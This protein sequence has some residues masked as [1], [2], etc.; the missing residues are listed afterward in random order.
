[1]DVKNRLDGQ[2]GTDNSTSFIQSLEIYTDPTGKTTA[3]WFVDLLASPV[4]LESFNSFEITGD[5][6]EVSTYGFASE[7][8][9]WTVGQLST[10]LQIPV[11]IKQLAYLSESPFPST[12]I[13]S[14]SRDMAFKEVP[15]SARP[16]P[17]FCL[18]KNGLVQGYSKLL[19]RGLAGGALKYDGSL[20]PDAIQF[21]WRFDEESIPYLAEIMPVI[22]DGCS[23]AMTTVEDGF[24]NYRD[25]EYPAPWDDV[26]G[27]PCT[28]MAGYE[29]RG[30]RLGAPQWIPN[31]HIG[32]ITSQSLDVYSEALSRISSGERNEALERLNTLANDGAGPY[33]IHGINTL[34]YSF[35]LPKLKEHP[36]VISEVEYLARQNIEQCMVDQSTNAIANL[37]ISYFLVGDL[38]RSEQTLLEALE[39]KDKFAEDEASFFLNLVYS[40][41]GEEAL[42]TEYK[43][44]SDAAG[45]YEPPEWFEPRQSAGQKAESNISSSVLGQNPFC[46]G[47]GNK[48]TSDDQKFCPNC[49]SRR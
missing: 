48:F 18:R 46:S 6:G 11:L 1:L 13:M 25:L 47:C 37:G 15:E 17:F 44:R 12:Q 49:G 16:T 10:K 26:V 28:F 32:E 5:D 2:W 42:A 4:P 30:S 22:V 45:G 41:K 40:A 23:Y 24:E 39:Q 29:S 36:E 43:K 33:L 38:E 21:G 35:L 20:F 3:Y 19:S 7:K 9:G 8:G 31:T 14:F 27:S 34:I